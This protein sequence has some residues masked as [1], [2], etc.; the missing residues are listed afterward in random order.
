MSEKLSQVHITW[1]SLSGIT[2]NW[3]L[4]NAQAHGNPWVDLRTQPQCS[5]SK[6]TC[7]TLCTS[8]A[9]HAKAF[10]LT[11]ST[12]CLYNVILKLWPTTCRLISN[13]ALIS[14]YWRIR[15]L[16][17]ASQQVHKSPMLFCNIRFRFQWAY[18]TL[19]KHKR[20]LISYILILT[21]ISYYKNITN[22]PI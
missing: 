7:L 19:Q 16:L 18:S 21:P 8:S 12:K 11:T 14:L 9:I 2:P 4:A 1:T 22:I 5:L 15:M 6:P 13:E 17:I 3:Y 20:I 10:L